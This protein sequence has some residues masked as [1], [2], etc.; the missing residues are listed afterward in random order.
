MFDLKKRVIDWEECFN[1]KEFEEEYYYN[2]ELG[3]IYSR[4][5][6]LF[7]LWC[8]V[9]CKVIVKVYSTDGYNTEEKDDI[10]FEQLMEIKDK[11]VWETI[12]EG[13][14]KDKYYTYEIHF[15]NL[16]LYS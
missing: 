15:D 14:L 12:I 8:P 4:E 3:N 1:S 10:L 2:G 6:T 7:R 5:S 9:A 13:D 16:C 11:G